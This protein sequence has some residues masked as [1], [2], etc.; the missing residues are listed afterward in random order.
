M[1]VKLL[2]TWVTQAP[3]DVSV[4]RVVVFVTFDSYSRVHWLPILAKWS[5]AGMKIFGK[6]VM[7]WQEDMH[8]MS[9]VQVSVPQKDFFLG[10]PMFKWACAIL[11]LWI[12][13]FQ[14]FVLNIVNF[15]TRSIKIRNLKKQRYLFNSRC[16]IRNSSVDYNEVKN[17]F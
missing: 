3:G 16:K 10:K 17:V 13:S 1:L 12:F 15:L 4:T 7:P 8:Q 2:N 5:I 9:W 11:L 6:K 14:K